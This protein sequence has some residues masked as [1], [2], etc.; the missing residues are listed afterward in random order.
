MSLLS[1]FN[2]VGTAQEK[3]S[4]EISLGELLKVTPDL[5]DHSCYSNSDRKSRAAVRRAPTTTLTTTTSG[6]RT[7]SSS[8]THPPRR[9]RD[10]VKEE[11][12]LLDANYPSKSK[13]C[14]GLQGSRLTSISEHD[15]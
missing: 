7:A 13:W 10:G 14:L 11:V 6:Q 5:A 2:F 8:P 1:D 12:H 9:A 3:I 4:N 15:G